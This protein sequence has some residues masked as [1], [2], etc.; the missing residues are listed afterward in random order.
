MENKWLA[1]W[2]WSS[3]DQL[4]SNTHWLFRTVF[5]CPRRKKKAELQI[6]G[7]QRYEAYINGQFVGRGPGAQCDLDANYDKFEVRD[8]LK[9]GRNIIIVKVYFCEVAPMS[10]AYRIYSGK[11][12]LLAQIQMEQEVIC[13]TDY[14][15]LV[16][17]DAS[18]VRV[19]QR[20]SNW[21][22]YHEC[23]DASKLIK[24]LH[25][26]SISR[27]GWNKAI[28]LEK[29]PIE[30]V[31]LHAR[32]IPT[33][34]VTDV[35][36]SQ[37]YT[38]TM[39]SCYEHDKTKQD[40]VN[41]DALYTQ[42]HSTCILRKSEQET[43]PRLVLDF[44]KVCAGYIHL[45]IKDGHGKIN[46]FLGESL[47]ASFAD[48]I[49]LAG[50]TLNY[51]GF[52]RRSMRY[53]ILDATE[54]CDTIELEQ[55]Y[56]EQVRYP[57]EIKGGFTSSDPVLNKTWRVSGTTV[58]ACS[59][60]FYE[61]CPWRE[62]ALWIGDVQIDGRVTAYQFGDMR[63]LAESIRRIAAIASPDGWLPSVG[64][65]YMS[66][67]QT[68]DNF[69]PD[70][71]L[72]WILCLS[73][74]FRYTNDITF[75]KQMY[76][77]AIDHI[78]YFI[79]QLDKNYLLGNCTR[80]TW[81]CF[82]DWTEHIDRRDYVAAIQ[83]HMVEALSEMAVL[84]QTVGDMQNH[85][86]FGDLA[87]S[88]K[89]AINEIFWSAKRNAYVD[90]VVGPRY[91]QSVNCSRQTNVL[92]VVWDI[93]DQARQ[94]TI[95]KSVLCNPSIAL[96]T[97][98]FF[99]HYTIRALFK[100]GY[101]DE[102]LELIRQYWG[103]MLE[104]G[105]TTF[106]ETF[107]FD[108]YGGKSPERFWSLCHG[109]SCAPGYVLQS[110]LLGIRPITSGWRDVQIS[111][112]L[113]SLQWVKGR[114]PTPRGNIDVSVEHSQN[115]YSFKLQLPNKTRAL[116]SLPFSKMAFER[117]YVNNKLKSLDESKDVIIRKRTKHW[118]LFEVQTMKKIT[119][120]VDNEKMR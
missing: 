13:K 7:Q 54:I 69:L 30:N 9:P 49:L 96:I 67:E 52:E 8:Y 36:P 62:Q 14:G 10:Y 113:G 93:A 50:G 16:R 79:R 37:V 117:V 15:W 61:D 29:P 105:A 97:T 81:W 59:Y 51:C 77:V 1:K 76:R 19:G 120:D 41:P 116:V 56:F 53:L 11:P 3:K 32:Q 104:R 25:S 110:E 100:L 39:A 34:D 33:L 106:W 21:G 38:Q 47:N 75:V 2:I 115:K 86:Y 99:N 27:H 109:F 73:D 57:F 64:P 35:Y 58:Q 4:Q 63:L 31:Y 55:V 87:G 17:E 28:V 72:D 43:T 24:N 92:A 83:M 44:G 65:G 108:N 80:P 84:A 78:G 112:Q 119:I 60:D 90:C 70:H 74:Y 118:I 98:G 42:N 5:N 111:P 91:K 89:A 82:V 85:S 71:S 48:S 107:G 88:V 26:L 94:K 103:A 46:L 102:A 18:Y 40:I 12:G 114:V 6:V 66:F 45:K 23:F 101:A 68:A 22:G 95:Y 20:I